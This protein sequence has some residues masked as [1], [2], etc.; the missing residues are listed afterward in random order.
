MEH[1]V[2]AEGLTADSHKFQTT[3]SRWRLRVSGLI[4]RSQNMQI[5]LKIDIYRSSE[6]IG[7][8]ARATIT[9]AT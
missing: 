2:C 4:G 1:G 6:I 3:S 9:R 8:A 5:S 7:N